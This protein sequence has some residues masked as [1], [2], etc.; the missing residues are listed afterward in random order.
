MEE[1]VFERLSNAHRPYVAELR[2]LLEKMEAPFR[3]GDRVGIKLHWGERGNRSF[4]PPDYAREIAHW[5]K[6]AGASPFLFDTTVLYSGGRR[7]AEDSLQTAAEHSTISSPPSPT[8]RRPWTSTT[9]STS[10]GSTVH[11][12]RVRCRSSLPFNFLGVTRSICLNQAVHPICAGSRRTG[13]TGS[14]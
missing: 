5:L 4:L 14:W 11:H 7:K 6:E 8:T 2:R 10:S 3:G 9:A 13:L 1:I 12:P